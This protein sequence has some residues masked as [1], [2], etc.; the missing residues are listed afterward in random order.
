MPACAQASRGRLTT[1]YQAGHPCLSRELALLCLDS[2]PPSCLTCALQL[3]S[4]AQLPAAQPI[5]LPPRHS[6]PPTKPPPCL[7]CL[8]ATAT[9][10]PLCVPAAATWAAW[11]T[12]PSVQ[13]AGTA[14]RLQCGARATSLC[15]PA[16]ASMP[17]AAAVE[18]SRAPRHP[19]SGQTL[20][21]GQ[22]P[23]R[24][25][26]YQTQQ[27]Q[28]AAGTWRPWRQQPRLTKAGRGGG[29]AYGLPHWPPRCRLAAAP[30]AA[31]GRPRHRHRHPSLCHATSL[32]G[33]W[34][35][36]WMPLRPLRPLALLAIPQW[37]A[38]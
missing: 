16:A 7:A 34:S 15:G 19:R 35:K 2:A 31:A 5:K 24:C 25:A 17:A 12:S 11:A 26:T 6:L 36:W 33:E 3:L 28:Q 22:A 13:A 10:M 23:L 37:S 27:A 8:Q 1:P 18:G 21:S 29:T 4:A 38:A 9:T 30:A 14:E 20:P 32:L